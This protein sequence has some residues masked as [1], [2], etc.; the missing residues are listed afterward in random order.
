MHFK[1]INPFQCLHGLQKLFIHKFDPTAAVRTKKIRNPI[2]VA[3]NQLYEENEKGFENCI[4]HK[5]G[6]P[7]LGV[8][9]NLDIY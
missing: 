2:N 4:I 5:T 1:Q 3:S 7:T 8:V 9:E 6:Q